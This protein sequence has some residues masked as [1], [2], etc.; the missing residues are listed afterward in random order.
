[1]PPV[2][3]KLRLPPPGPDMYADFKEG[4]MA[5]FGLELLPT[6]C[7]SVPNSEATA[8]LNP[9]PL[10]AFPNRA[11]SPSPS[12]VPT[13]VP[14]DTL[15]SPLSPP[16]YVP[17]PVVRQVPCALHYTLVSP[18]FA[19]MAPTSYPASCT[20]PCFPVVA[21]AHKPSPAA[22]SLESGPDSLLVPS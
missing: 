6:L 22:P 9:P 21:P 19:A 5:Y 3:A 18:K 12:P 16:P 14:L 11:V 17:P 15:V 10:A 20:Q 13:T 7:A 1:M 4:L 2:L 8:L